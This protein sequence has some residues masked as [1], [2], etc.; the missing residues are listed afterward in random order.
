MSVSSSTQV[1][2]WFICGFLFFAT[3]L[4]YM[5]RHTLSNVAP[6]I[7]EEF[8]LDNAQLGLLLA[9]FSY[10]YGIMQ[11]VTGLILDRVNVRLGYALAVCWWSLAG[12]ATGMVHGFWQLFGCRMMLGVGEAANWPAAMRIVSRILPPEKRSLANGIFTS[13]SSI[14]AL[15]TPLLMIWITQRW[16]WRSGFV[17]VGLLG[18]V[19]VVGWLL[20]VRIPEDGKKERQER[21]SATPETTRAS[22]PSLSHGSSHGSPWDEI[23]NSR[24]F[25]GLIVASAFYTPCLFFY[26]TWMPTYL[27][28]E[29]GFDFG[30][31]LGGTM[32]VPFIGLDVGYLLGGFVVLAL[33]RRGFPVAISRKLV[34]GVGAAIM[35]LAIAVPWVE[36]TTAAMTL[37]FLTTMSLASWQ[38]NYLSFV[39][40][41]SRENVSGVSGV[42]GGAGAFS[43]AFFIWLTG[44][45]S[46]TTGSFALVF[47]GLG[48]LPLIATFGILVIMGRMPDA[49]PAHEDR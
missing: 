18:I 19:W 4:N 39:E 48:I 20:F 7:Q 17:A 30:M 32:I 36:T 47:A 37:I 28:Q 44:W 35:L 42:V 43:A 49:R 16:G 25:W 34:I 46:K 6:L 12:A 15:I 8:S 27:V 26:A 41:V 5:D 38:S 10:S 22:S 29:R 24:R 11:A 23:L 21:E 3:V 2:P 40:E 1:R 14:G 45:V 13:G 33:V 31:K 9:A